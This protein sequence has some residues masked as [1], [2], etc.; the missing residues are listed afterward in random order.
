MLTSLCLT[1]KRKVALHFGLEEFEFD[2]TFKLVGL[3]FKPAF[4]SSS[5]LL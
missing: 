5:A 1:A 4:H 3:P 2:P